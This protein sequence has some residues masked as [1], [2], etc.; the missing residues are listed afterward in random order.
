MMLTALL[1]L[2]VSN[3]PGHKSPFLFSIGIFSIYLVSTGYRYISLD[4]LHKGQKPQAIDWFLTSLMALFGLFLVGG[5]ILQLIGLIDIMYDRSFGTVM[6]V[7]GGFSVMMVV[8]DINGFRGKVQYKNHWLLMHIS[9]M[10]GANIAAFTA[11]LVVNNKFLPN[12]V[13]W[14]LPTV[15]G[16]P[17][18]MYWHKKQKK[19]PGMKIEVKK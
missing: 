4:D 18:M 5:G 10:I 8:Q 2:V 11:F 16:I 19:I 1:A 9:R 14:L 15:I 12:I 13:A 7:F 17:L 6:L 3:L